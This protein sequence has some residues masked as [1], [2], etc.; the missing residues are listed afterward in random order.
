M[1]LPEGSA[2][3]NHRELADGLWLLN[4]G[5]LLMTELCGLEVLI[6]AVLTRCAQSFARHPIA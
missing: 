4:H 3:T 2:F 5:W 1:G 6:H